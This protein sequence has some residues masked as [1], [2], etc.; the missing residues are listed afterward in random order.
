M[1]SKPMPSLPTPDTSVQLLLKDNASLRTQLS[2]LRRQLDW[3][4]RQ[5]F[6][7]KSERR[8]V[9][10][11]G[12]EQLNLEQ[13]EQT[14]TPPEVRP[15][16]I[17]A[18]TR[19]PRKSVDQGKDEPELFFDPAK[20]PVQEIIL[21][22]PQTEG[23]SPDQFE[24]ISQ[25]VTHHLAQR[26]GSYVVLKYVRP[27]VKIKATQTLSCP[28]A[29]QSVIV[30]SR[31]DVSFVTGMIVDKFVYHLPLYRQHQRLGASA[32]TVS[33]QWLTQITHAAASLLQPIAEA[34]LASIRR[35]RVIAMDETPIKAGV[36]KPGKMHTGYFW[37][38]YGEQDE[39]SFLYFPSRSHRHVLEALGNSPPPGRVLLSDGYDA[40][41]RYAIATKITHAQCW[42][43]TRRHAFEARDLEPD[44]GDR[45]L[46]YI[47]KLYEIERMIATRGLF[48]ADKCAYRQAHAKPVVEAFFRWVGEQFAAQGLLPSSPMSKALAYA[49]EREAGLKVYLDDPE[50]AMDTNHLERG[51]RP[52]PMG[53]RNWL[54]CWTEVGAKHVGTLQSLLSTCKLHQ[55]DP[56]DYLIDVLQRISIHPASRVEELTPRLWK[57]HFAANPLRSQIQFS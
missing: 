38:V 28:P 57:Q 48:G 18:H 8:L 35:S 41:S 46:D 50:V 5:V 3:F 30:G 49:R 47:G 45:A 53:R 26:P 27:V 40:Y 43:H 22:D 24:V 16:Q 4:Q 12:Q 11:P 25:K 51:L 7:Q 56:F 15:T 13:P 37:P 42:A 6:G 33:R 2:E 32:I 34:Q 19:S 21:A 17:G 10:A 14:D 29:P 39:L 55:I 9:H 44:R 20:V 54:F 52:V 36:A 31:A 1:N 23:L